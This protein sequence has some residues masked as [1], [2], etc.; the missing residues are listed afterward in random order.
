[1]SSSTS[2]LSDVSKL[3]SALAISKINLNA[4]NLELGVRVRAA[5]DD[6]V[7][8]VDALLAQYWLGQTYLVQT[9]RAFYDNKDY[10]ELASGLYAASLAF[11]EVLGIESDFGE[12][13][14]FIKATSA[15]MSQ[16]L[17]K[18]SLTLEN[19]YAAYIDRSKFDGSPTNI[20]ETQYTFILAEDWLGLVKIANAYLQ[21]VEQSEMVEA[22][23]YLN[24]V[25][26]NINRA[27]RMM[28][29]VSLV[30]RRVLAILGGEMNRRYYLR[31]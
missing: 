30:D 7:I 1:M 22:Q 16:V 4:L 2:H 5:V 26:S 3:V 31:M 8:R 24:A 12:S 13:V 29:S 10:S 14:E 19:Q 20:D 6:E 28:D 27:L 25:F 11:N 15:S 9:I 23:P 17:R 18:F 21:M